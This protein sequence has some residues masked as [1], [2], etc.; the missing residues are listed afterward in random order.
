M[1]KRVSEKEL[2][3]IKMAMDAESKIHIYKRYQALYLFLSGRT[4]K[5]TAEILGITSTTVSNIHRAY[6]QEGL[7][8]IPFK[9]IPGRPSRLDVT[10][11]ADLRTVILEKV[12]SDVGFIAEFNWTAGLIVQ[13]I[14]RM[15]G[16][17]YTVSG[18]TRI[19]DRMGLSYTRPTYVLAKADKEKQTQFLEDFEE[20]KKNCWMTKSNAFSL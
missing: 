20:L 19:L 4:C 14:H 3:L 5:E 17:D 12:P 18:V 6:K 1:K 10:Q 11:L 13:Y 8:G 9:L 7:A 2:N 16:L 15:Y